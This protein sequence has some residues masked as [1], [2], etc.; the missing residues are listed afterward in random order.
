MRLKV[1]LHGT[2]MLH[3]VVD[4][5]I[6][7][8]HQRTMKPVLHKEPYGH[9]CNTTIS[10]CTK[11]P[12]LFIPLL[13]SLLGWCATSPRCYCSHCGS[14]SGQNRSAVLMTTGVNGKRELVPFFFQPVYIFHSVPG[15]SFLTTLL[16]ISLLSLS[17]KCRS[18]HSSLI[19]PVNPDEN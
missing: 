9:I 18:L 17:L 15:N 19:L 7:L 14:F 11:S 3:H 16:S 2:Q 4:Q 5:Q 13:L 12:V 6:A 10:T 1:S 8:P